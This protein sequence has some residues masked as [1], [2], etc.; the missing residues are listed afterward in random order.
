VA[1]IKNVFFRLNGPEYK[2]K[3]EIVYEQVRKAILDGLIKPGDKLETD[4]IA[5]ALSVSRMPVREAIKRL[6]LEGWV[7]VKPHKEVRV[8]SV[9]KAQIKDVFA[10]RAMLES[11]AAREAAGKISEAQINLLWQTYRNMEKLV[12]SGDTARQLTKNRE[13]HEIIHKI[14]ENK[15]LQSMAS[16]LFDSIERYRLQFLSLPLRPKEVLK[17]HLKLIE[18]I[19][20]HD[21]G[22]SEILMRRHIENTGKIMLGY[23]EK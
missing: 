3:T 14:S 16:S 12:Q 7:D 20:S 13:F 15:V 21:M 11:L 17:D 9:T 22:S 4:A 6:Q 5:A 2:G 1:S 19:E 23:A 10:V 18:A 8:V